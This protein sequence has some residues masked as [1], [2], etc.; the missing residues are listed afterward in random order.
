M[1]Q[2]LKGLPGVK[3]LVDDSLVVGRNQAEHDERLRP[4]L[5][6]LVQEEK[7]DLEKCLFSASR[8]EYIGKI[9]DGQRLRKDPS[10][11]QAIVNFPEPRDVKELR[12]FLGMA[13]QLMKYC[14]DL[15][16]HTKPLIDLLRS[17]TAWLWGPQQAAAFNYLK[18][19]LASEHVLSIYNPERETVVSADASNYGLG[20]VLL[21]K[22]PSG[23]LKPVAYASRSMTDIECRYAQIEKEGLALTWVLEITCLAF[24]R[25]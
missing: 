9:I 22:Q 20:A 7:L 19:E 13:N 21:Q 3:C 10:K 6:R 2:V 18:Q 11:V 4:V 8:L 1:V 14:P 17:N 12:R 15:A 24:Q 16:E 23:E 25:S 5:D